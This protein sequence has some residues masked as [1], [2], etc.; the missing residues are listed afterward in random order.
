[1]SVVRICFLKT[2]EEIIPTY[3]IADS[4]QRGKA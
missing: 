3:K 1:M 4:Y 2:L